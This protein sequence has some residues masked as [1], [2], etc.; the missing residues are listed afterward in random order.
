MGR[1]KRQR[2]R[3]RDPDV[4]RHQV[5]LLGSTF[6]LRSQSVEHLPDM[7]PPLCIKGFAA[8]LYMIFAPH[9]GRLSSRTRPSQSTLRV[10]GGSRVGT[11]NGGLLPETSNCY[12]H[13]GKAG[14]LPF[15]AKAVDH[16]ALR[17]PIVAASQGRAH[18][19]PVPAPLR[20]PG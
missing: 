17:L 19:I 16:Y 8:S 7:P 13:P 15:Y 1:S 2:G 5:T 20:T 10:H 4:V 12:C 9:F 11:L 18:S 14:G 6:F 3:Y